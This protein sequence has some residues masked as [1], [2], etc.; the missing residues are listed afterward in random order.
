MASSRA[1][2]LY[3]LEALDT[4]IQ[5]DQDNFTCVYSSD[6]PIPPFQTDVVSFPFLHSSRF[7]ALSRDPLQFAGIPPPGVLYKTSIVFSLAEGPGM[8]FKALS[9]FALRN[10]DLTKIERR[11]HSHSLPS[12]ASVATLCSYPLTHLFS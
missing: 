5:D 10:I 1:G 3:G 7:I 2:E 8:L 6:P 11:V 4:A 12:P 9:C